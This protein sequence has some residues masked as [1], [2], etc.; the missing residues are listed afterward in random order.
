M[1]T[2]SPC[3]NRSTTTAPTHL[4]DPLTENSVSTRFNNYDNRPIKPLDQNM[5][6]SKLNQYPVDPYLLPFDGQ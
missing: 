5:L 6:Q 4:D 3:Y 2:P 1:R